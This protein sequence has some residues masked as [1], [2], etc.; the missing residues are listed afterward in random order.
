MENFIKISNI[1]ILIFKK[2][3]LWSYDIKSS[4]FAK[5]KLNLLLKDMRIR[6]IDL[7]RNM[8]STALEQYRATDR[9]LKFQTVK[10]MAQGTFNLRLKVKQMSQ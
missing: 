2:R 10:F 9:I 1:L 8:N 4:F 6:L 5:L 3:P 7:L